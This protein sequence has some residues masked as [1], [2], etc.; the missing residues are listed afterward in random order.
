MRFAHDAVQVLEDLEALV[1]LLSSR[2]SDAQ[3]SANSLQNEVT[4]LHAAADQSSKDQAACNSQH[5]TLKKEAGIAKRVLAPAALLCTKWSSASILEAYPAPDQMW[6]DCMHSLAPI[7]FEPFPSLTT[8]RLCCFCVGSDPSPFTV[9]V[10][11][12]N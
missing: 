7:T 4:T 3:C 8:S 5:N 10:A 9:E 6:T 1:K 12:R 11:Y 2:A